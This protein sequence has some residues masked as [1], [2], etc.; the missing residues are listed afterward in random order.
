MGFVLSGPCLDGCG[1]MGLITHNALL[2]VYFATQTQEIRRRAL[3]QVRAK[4]GE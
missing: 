1:P 3:E 4:K 2:W